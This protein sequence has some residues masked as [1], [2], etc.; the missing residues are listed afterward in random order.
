MVR[1]IS[2]ALSNADAA[3]AATYAANADAY[4]AKLQALDKEISTLVDQVP[5]ERRKIVTSHDALGY[6]ADRYGFTIVGSVIPALSTEAGDP[7]AQDIAK[8]VDGIKAEGV[9]AI[10][11]ESM[12]NPR[13][14]ERVAQEAG[15]RIGPELYTDALGGPDS[16]GATFI[17]A[18][19]A[20]ARTLIELLR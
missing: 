20:N 3:N 13:L 18:M 8:L 12:A 16:D 14:V 15:V 1:N 7:S 9:K 17:D 2:A 5:A 4:I 10:F 19:R 11:L 6:F